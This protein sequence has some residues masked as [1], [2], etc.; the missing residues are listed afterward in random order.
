[1]IAKHNITSGRVGQR[2]PNP[3]RSRI[4]GLMKENPEYRR[5]MQKHGRQLEENNVEVITQDQVA[6]VRNQARNVVHNIEQKL[7]KA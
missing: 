5:L 1:M 3:C 6:E 7:I 4:T 2:H